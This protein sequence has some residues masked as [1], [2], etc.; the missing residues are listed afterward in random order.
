MLS[1]VGPDG[2]SSSLTP[3]G[4]D[5]RVRSSPRLGAIV[6]LDGHVNAENTIVLS[7]DA[8]TRLVDETYWLNRRVADWPAGVEQEL[9][10]RAAGRVLAHEIGHYLLG[11]RAHTPDGLM[12]AGFGASALLDPARLGFEIPRQLVPRLSGRLAQLAGAPSAIAQVE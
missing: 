2:C 1:V 7:I 8:I 12:R 10:G 6:F 4:H 5:P 9:V 3:L 11:W